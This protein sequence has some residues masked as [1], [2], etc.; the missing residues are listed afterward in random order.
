MTKKKNCY[1]SIASKI[2]LSTNTFQYCS[3]SDMF[4]NGDKRR[5][6]LNVG[7]VMRQGIRSI[8]RAFTFQFERKGNLNNFTSEL[9]RVAQWFESLRSC[10]EGCGFDILSSYD[11]SSR[12][13]HYKWLVSCAITW[14]CKT[15]AVLNAKQTVDSHARL[16]CWRFERKCLSEIRQRGTRKQ[17]FCYTLLVTNH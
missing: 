9:A 8:I 17:P 2:C 1:N 7:S 5:L 10:I 4:W 6:S 15:S 11:V 14:W 16:F 3:W 12:R 13:I